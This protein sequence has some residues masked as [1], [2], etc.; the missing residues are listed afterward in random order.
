MANW[1]VFIPCVPYQWAS[2]A[3]LDYLF[4][5]HQLGTV[6]NVSFI[7]SQDGTGIDTTVYFHSWYDTESAEYIRDTVLSGAPAYLA[8]ND[9]NEFLTLYKVQPTDNIKAELTTL[10]RHVGLQC[11]TCLNRDDLEEDDD[12]Y[13]KFYCTS[14]WFKRNNEEA[15]RTKE[16]NIKNMRLKMNNIWSSQDP[17]KAYEL[18][19]LLVEIQ[20][21]EDEIAI[22]KTQ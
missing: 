15:I 6:H 2:Y 13:G 1:G 5:W 10:R 11:M 12:D 22:L 17:Q 19:D 14:C 18:E 9:F 4:Q 16:R 3:A 20:E 21:L 7:K 8:L